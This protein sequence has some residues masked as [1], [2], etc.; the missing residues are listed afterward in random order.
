M[1][2]VHAGGAVKQIAK[3]VNVRRSSNA[4]DSGD[5]TGLL[6]AHRLDLFAREALDKGDG[7]VE[8]LRIL[9]DTDHVAVAG[10]LLVQDQL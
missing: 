9:V 4:L 5:Q 10:D 6:G 2:H 3:A 8:V 7:G 1:T